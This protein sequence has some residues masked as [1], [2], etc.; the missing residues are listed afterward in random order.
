VK[1][2]FAA[3]SAV[4][5]VAFGTMGILVVAMGLGF[6]ATIPGALFG[7]AQQTVGA[8]ELALKSIPAAALKDYQDAAAK[9]CPGLNWTVLA[10]IGEVES[11]HGRLKDPKTGLPA[12]GVLSG[13]NFAGAEG[14]MQFEPATWAEWLV[15][16]AAHGFADLVNVYDHTA[17]AFG[18]AWTL[19]HNGAAQAG[20]LRQALW[21]YNHS[22]SYVDLVLSWAAKYAADVTQTAPVPVASLRTG[23]PFAGAC[24]PTI[25]QPYGPTTFT[26]EP[27]IGGVHFHTGIDMSCA[28]GTPIHS[29]TD[30]VAHVGNGYNGGFGNYVAVEVQLL[31]PGDSQPQRYFVRYQHLELTLVSEGAA[32]HAGEL[33]GLEGST[34]LSTG[35]HLHF[36]V[37]RGANNIRQ[38][39]SPMPLLAVG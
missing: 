34:G 15:W 5:F 28:A 6:M 14:P 26:L 29:V 10:G 13:A 25:N 7:A 33:V 11:D 31:L 23:D 12:A 9:V 20:G 32:V 2:Q 22:W 27:L 1:K 39:V 17:A 4:A 8:S 35:P 37:D 38:S 24:R 36:E 18:A 30:G 19:C 21:D 3:V 16:A